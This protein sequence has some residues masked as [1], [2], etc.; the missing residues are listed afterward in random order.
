MS[1]CL[2]F[3]QRC[4]LFFFFFIFLNNTASEREREKREEYERERESEGERNRSMREREN[5]NNKSRSTQPHT[6]THTH[7]ITQLTRSWTC[8]CFLFIRKSLSTRHSLANLSCAVRSAFKIAS[9]LAFREDEFVLVLPHKAILSHAVGA[10]VE[11]TVTSVNL[12][13]RGMRGMGM[14]HF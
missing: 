3:L 10:E 2:K 4:T 5:D 14:L 9:C 12:G 6:H 8:A 1:I 7:H 13:A 11:A